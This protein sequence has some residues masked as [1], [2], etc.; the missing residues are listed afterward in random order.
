MK[1]AAI[2]IDRWKLPTFSRH[3]KEAGFSYEEGHTIGPVLFL[4]VAV[5]DGQAQRLA[6]VVLAANTECARSKK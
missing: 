2:A 3:L 1:Q 4:K 6:Q 5:P